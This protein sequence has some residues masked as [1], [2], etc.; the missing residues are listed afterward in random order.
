MNNLAPTIKY[1]QAGVHDYV[2]RE[3]VHSAN[4]KSQQRTHYSSP[5][6]LRQVMH[7]HELARFSLQLAQ[8]CAHKMHSAMMRR[9]SQECLNKEKSARHN[10]PGAPAVGG[11]THHHRLTLA[12][13]A[14]EF[15]QS[16]APPGVPKPPALV[17]VNDQQPNAPNGANLRNL[18]T[19]A[20]HEPRRTKT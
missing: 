13:V 3:G 6:Q 4:A 19:F 17:L 10:A 2:K 9:Y 12:E 18:P 5:Q 8:V 16:S 7:E 15:D 1:L 11:L 20:I 14:A